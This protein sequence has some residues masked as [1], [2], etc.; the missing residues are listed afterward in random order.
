MLSRLFGPKDGLAFFYFSPE[1]DPENYTQFIANGPPAD[2]RLGI[3]VLHGK[4]VVVKK[5]ADMSESSGIS[6]ELLDSETMMEESIEARLVVDATGRFHRFISTEERIERMEGLNTNAYWAYFQCPG[7]EADVPLRHYE[8]INTNHICLPEGW[9]WVIKLPSCEGSSIPNLTA[10]INHLLDLNAAKVPADSYPS[11]PELINRFQVKFRWVFSIGF[12]LRSDVVYPEDISSYGSNEVE[13]KFN[14]IVSRYQKVSELMQKHKLI[15]DLYGSG[16]T[17]FV[18]KGLAF[19]APRVTGKDWLAIGDATSFTNPLYSPGINAN[20]S[21]SIYA[22]EMTN[23][24]L[25]TKN[26]S[27]KKDLLQRYEQF[28]K[29][30]IPN[31]QRM[32]VFN[33]VCMRSPELGPLGP[34]WQY[35]CGTGNE[36]FQ[37]ASN[38]NLQ[39]VHELLT[40]WDWGSNQ[41]AFIAFSKLAMQML[42]G[43]PDAKLSPMTIDAVK[44]SLGRALEAGDVF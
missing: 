34:I 38:L 26:T 36:K 31:L 11:V 25:S 39:N 27:S 44:T 6:I 28:C 37:N 17:W 41:E 18:R 3:N 10:M 32:N 29:D 23:D 40:T 30:R 20:M 35:L 8:S 19:R 13:Q 7:D 43:P 2:F 22:A 21:T 9:A 4:E 42:D 12:A 15:Q 24:Y 5:K 1:G 14:W 33:Y 16:T